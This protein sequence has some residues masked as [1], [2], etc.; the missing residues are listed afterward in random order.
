MSTPAGSSSSSEKVN[1]HSTL[2]Y[3]AMIYSRR[4]STYII[5]IRAVVPSRR[6][7]IREKKSK[8]NRN[9]NP[10][11]PQTLTLDLIEKGQRKESVTG[12]S[13]AKQR[14]HLAA[15]NHVPNLTGQREKTPVAGGGRR[16]CSSSPTKGAATEPLDGGAFTREC[17]HAPARGPEGRHCISSWPWPS[18]SWC[19]KKRTEGRAPPCRKKRARGRAPP[20]PALGWAAPLPSRRQ[21]GGRSTLRAAAREKVKER[22]RA[23]ISAR[24]RRSGPREREQQ[25]GGAVATERGSGGLCI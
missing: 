16:C 22:S 6:S 24:R 11:P 12:N 13:P 15:P 21:D 9:E 23:P 7:L 18:G 20:S 8:E 4:S 3:P 25:S 17:T 10:N 19:R 14:R 5:G 1:V 2:T